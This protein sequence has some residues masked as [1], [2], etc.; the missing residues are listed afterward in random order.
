[1]LKKKNNFNVY[2]MV[3]RYELSLYDFVCKIKFYILKD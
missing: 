2:V 3:V 1:M